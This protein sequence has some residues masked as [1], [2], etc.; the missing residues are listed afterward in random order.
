MIDT[1]MESV[2]IYEKC[3]QNEESNMKNRIQTVLNEAYI[4][5]LLNPL[6]VVVF[7]ENTEHEKMVTGQISNLVSLADAKYLG[8]NEH[9]MIGGFTIFAQFS[10]E[11]NKSKFITSLKKLMEKRHPEIGYRYETAEEKTNTI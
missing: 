9:D 7:V 2:C 10:S 1:F 6:E 11:A 3:L 5:E 8:L 4:K